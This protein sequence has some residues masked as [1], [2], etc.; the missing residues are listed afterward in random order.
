LGAVLWGLH[1]VQVESV[2]WITELKNTQSGLFYLLAIFLFLKWH[3][4]SESGDRHKIILHLLLLLCATFALLSKTSTVMLPIVLALCIWWL[5]DRW[6]WSTLKPLSPLF[7]LSAAAGLW[8]IWEQK[9]HSGALGS[10]WVQGFP[11]RVAVAGNSIW[12]YLGKLIWPHPLIFLYPR[13]EVSSPGLLSFM[14]GVAVVAVLLVLWRSRNGWTRPVFFAF[15][16]FVISLFPVLNFFDVYFFRY[17][18]VGDHFQYLA[19]MGPIVLGAV[20]IVYLL[21][22]QRLRVVVATALIA[23]CAMLTAQHAQVFK[24]D[25]TLWR[26]T[27]RKNPKAWLAYNNLASMYL[28]RDNIGAAIVELEITLRLH[29]HYSEGHANLANALYETGRIDEAITHFKLALE[30]EPDYGRIHNYLGVA[31]MAAGRL[32]EGI[33]H[34][35]KAI[36]IDPGD[37]TAHENLGIALMRNG[38]TEEGIAEFGEA[39]RVN[40]KGLDSRMR[41]AT[42][43]FSQSRHEEAATQFEEILKISPAHAPAHKFL[44]LTLIE[45]HQKDAA[46]RHLEEA[47][48]LEPGDTEVRHRLNELLRSKDK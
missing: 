25:E 12:F 31:L 16:Y 7:V 41:Y 6:N 21:R 20:A 11:E 45:L 15:A 33:T 3:G 32:E 17:S 47:G 35:R 27:V 46:V 28:E 22:S 4:R 44:G 43:L 1:P 10:E 9:F 40:P 42:A 38:R 5:G 29:P 34:I 36:E 26:D 2:A 37:T 19:S 30:G 39:V 24:D 8:T 48:R 23:A 14:P 18:F 13:W